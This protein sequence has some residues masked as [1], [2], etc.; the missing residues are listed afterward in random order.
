M[1]KFLVLRDS[2]GYVQVTVPD[3][4]E[5]ELN[6]TVESLRYES[7]I[8]VYGKVLDRGC[9]RNKKMKTGEIEVIFKK[10]IEF[11]LV[12][13]KAKSLSFFRLNL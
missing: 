8:K 3:N 11:Y 9:N 2:Y 5:Q 7:V 4:R 12:C 10:F 6:S 1:N 13:V